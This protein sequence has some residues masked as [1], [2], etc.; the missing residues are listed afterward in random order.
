MQSE[1]FYK[2]HKNSIQKFQNKYNVEKENPFNNEEFLNDATKYVSKVGIRKDV[3]DKKQLIDNYM[4]KE[5]NVQNTMM[6]AFGSMI[7]YMY[8]NLSNLLPDNLKV[9]GDVAMNSIHD[10]Q[11]HFKFVSTAQDIISKGLIKVVK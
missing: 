8:G 1:E 7:S 5:F 2:K 10:Y 11:K 4:E 6:I 3:E 9:S